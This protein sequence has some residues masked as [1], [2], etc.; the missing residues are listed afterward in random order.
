MAKRKSKSS[1]PAG[2]SVRKTTGRK[3]KPP[4]PAD[5][6]FPYP[7]LTAFL[8]NLDC[9][10]DL[11][12]VTVLGQVAVVSD[13]HITYAA[14]GLRDGETIPQLLA[15]LEAALA[16]YADTDEITDELFG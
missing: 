12:H 11:G 10:L 5:P 14:L 15:R 7:T 8:T 2:R 4:A 9:H 16:R 1:S 13:E 3:A 6:T